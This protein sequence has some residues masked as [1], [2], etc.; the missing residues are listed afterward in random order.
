MCFCI[1][2]DTNHSLINCKLNWLF[3]ANV[4]NLLN[5]TAFYLLFVLKHIHISIKMSLWCN[6]S[7]M[8]FNLIYWHS[9]N[10]SFSHMFNSVKLMQGR[11]HYCQ[12]PKIIRYGQMVPPPIFDMLDAN[13]LH[14]ITL[15]S[16]C[17]EVDTMF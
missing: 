5:Q 6:L 16:L 7:E 8:A 14:S 17:Y 3:S 2:R 4:Q 11:N 15:H 12:P 1:W 9:G 10:R 13:L